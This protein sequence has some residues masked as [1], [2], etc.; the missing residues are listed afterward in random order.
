[1]TAVKRLALLHVSKS[2][3]DHFPFEAA[4]FENKQDEE[5]YPPAA[6]DEPSLI[7]L[8]T[9]WFETQV[10]CMWSL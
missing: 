7:K 2:L 8:E 9:R 1:M 5:P 6:Y 4:F 10:V 3:F